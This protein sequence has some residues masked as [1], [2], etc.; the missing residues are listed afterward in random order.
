MILVGRGLLEAFKKKHAD[1]RSQI[2]AWVAEVN[3][4]SWKTTMDVKERYCHASIL[5]DNRVVF[6]LKGNDYRLEV[7]IAFR[8]GVVKIH[9]VGTHAEY[10]KWET[11]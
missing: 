1:A 7:S 8:T 5:A 3:D 6:N 10:D 9:R 2:D 4:A 11:K